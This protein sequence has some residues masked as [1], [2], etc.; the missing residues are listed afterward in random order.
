MV[1]GRADGYVM[2]IFSLI[3]RLSGAPLRA[4]RARDSSVTNPYTDTKYHLL[5]PVSQISP[6]FQGK[7]FYKPFLF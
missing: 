3:Y 2:T 5:R 7:E 4:L 6:P 1:D